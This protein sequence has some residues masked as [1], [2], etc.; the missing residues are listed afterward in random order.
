MA[1]LAGGPPRGMPGPAAAA[2]LFSA[3]GRA[4][5]PRPGPGRGAAPIAPPP[6]ARA[7]R[8]RAR[9]A[10][11][12]RPDLALRGRHQRRR[13]HRHRHH[14]GRPHH[15]GTTGRCRHR[16]RRRGD[17]RRSAASRRWDRP[18]RCRR[19]GQLVAGDRRCRSDSPAGAHGLPAATP[20]GSGVP[21]RGGGQPRGR[22]GPPRGGSSTLVPPSRR[23]PSPAAGRGIHH[24]ASGAA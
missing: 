21:C 1:V 15:S 19:R 2:D 20:C 13:A 3:D 9:A 7:A 10:R 12:R 24:T 11:W 23:A 16:S 18:P 14:R 5:L 6:G 8:V 4:P 17:A 22:G